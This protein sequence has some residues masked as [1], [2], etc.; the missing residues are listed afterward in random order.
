MRYLIVN[1]DD[2]GISSGVNRG[3]LE[4]HQQGIVTSTTAMVNLPAAAAGIHLM[5]Q[6]APAVGIGLHFNFTR[7]RPVLAPEHVPSLVGADGQFYSLPDFMQRNPNFNAA[8]LRAEMEAQLARFIQL[9]G[10]LPDHFDAHHYVT[11][12][13]PDMFDMMLKLATRHKLPI[14]SAEKH[15]TLDAMRQVFM[16]RGYPATV[17]DT[18]PQMILQ[19]YA[20]NPKPLWPDTVERGFYRDGANLETLLEILQNVR[21]GVTELMCHPGYIDDLDDTYREPRE[22]ELQALIHPRVREVITA[23]DIQLIKFSELPR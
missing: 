15:M 5:Q 23:Q 14:R 4:A 8:E 6:Q 21:H 3:I 22:A 2:L 9:A 19:M 10:W 17:V 11:Y 20:A 1:A 7:G 18:L 16:G 12:L 13:N